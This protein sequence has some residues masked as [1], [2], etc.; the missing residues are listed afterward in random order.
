MPPPMPPHEFPHD[1]WIAGVAALPDGTCLTGCYDHAARVWN[2]SGELVVT[3]TGHTDAVT[4][5]A[6]VP[7]SESI[8]S[9]TCVSSSFDEN[10]RLWNVDLGA[11][12]AR[13]VAV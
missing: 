7:Q 4:G 1:D 5:V 10:L 9:H 11:R 12:T 8:D 6:W 13:C 3:L 2:S